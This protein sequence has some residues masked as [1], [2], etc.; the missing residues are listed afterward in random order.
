VFGRASCTEYDSIVTIPPLDILRCPV[1]RAQ[2][3]PDGDGLRCR[4]CAA[5]FPVVDD[6]PRMLDDRLPGIDAKRRELEGWPAMAKAHGWY[7]R[8]D[9]TDAHL[10]YLNRDLGWDDKNWRA[11]EHSFSLLLDR[12]VR[13]GMRVLE[14]G[15][16][17]AWAAQ[18]LVP[19][20]CEY[21]ATDILADDV[22]GLG[23]GAFYEERVGAFGRVQA[24]GEHLPFASRAF[25]LTYCVAALHHALDVGAMVR[26][27]ARV[28]RRGGWV[29]A[30]NEGT[31]ALG[32]PADVPDQAE[33]KG[34]G[35]NEHVHT[36]YA[37]LWAFTRAGLVVR[38]VEQAE[39]YGELA[40]RRI[41]GRLLRL[42]LVGRSASTFFSQTC[43]GY[44]GVSLYSHR[45]GA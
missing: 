30:L 12:Y 43:H 36:L 16:A 32:S 15:A 26:E 44:S 17:K 33:E 37:Y 1:C 42:P 27:M 5:V 13:P 9:E 31:R 3:D 39:G 24:D 34:F 4:G 35:I 8:D 28:T 11:T 19:L 22:I 23:R 18:H 45:P 6:M 10:P 40:G 14:V 21:V 41:A 2:V 20:G 25:D 29:C 38:R 7:E